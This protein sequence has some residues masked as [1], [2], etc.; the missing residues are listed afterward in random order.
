MLGALQWALATGLAT[1]LANFIISAIVE[2]GYLSIFVLMTAES[3]LIPIPSEVIMPFAGYLVFLNRLDF[4]FAVLAGTVGNLAGSLTAY[5]IGLYAGRSVVLRYGRYISLNEDHLKTT[6]RWFS[7]HGDKTIPVSRC[8]PLIRSYMSLP[9][10]F[11][12][13]KLKKFVPYT[14]LGSIPWNLNSACSP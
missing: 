12:G 10:G 4:V 14:F 9:A 8:L 1:Q 5:Y 7:R 3:M 11:A 13:M 2:G 6:E